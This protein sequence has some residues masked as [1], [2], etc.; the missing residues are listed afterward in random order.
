MIVDDDRDARELIGEVLAEAGYAVEVAGDGFEAMAKL[1]RSLPDL[2]LTD[3]RM[4]GMHGVDLAQQIRQQRDVPVV[5][6]TGAETFDLCTDAQAYGA[7]ACLM[8]P[9]NLEELLWTIDLALA[10][11]RREPAAGQRRLYAV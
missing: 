4:P 1:P 3:L 11:R 6:T 9:I 7:V 10:C 2:V 8:K 5:L